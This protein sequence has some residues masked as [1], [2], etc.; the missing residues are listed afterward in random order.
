M[1]ALLFI[2]L[3]FVCLD[4]EEPTFKSE[5]SQAIWLEAIS[6]FEKREYRQAGKTFTKLKRDTSDKASNA[7]VQSY[8]TACKGGDRIP[9]IQKEID[10]EKWIKAWAELERLK[11]SF[12]ST[13]LAPH[14]EEL[15]EVIYPEI[16]LSL[17]DFEEEPER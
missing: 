1:S 15:H 5:K 6:S 8:A 11:R 14:L 16:F 17:A 12:S 3:P 10:R 9:R 13:P 7:R 2:L 4:A